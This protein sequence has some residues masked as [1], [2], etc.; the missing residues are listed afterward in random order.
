MLEQLPRPL[1]TI[2]SVDACADAFV[3]G[4]AGRRRHVDVP[5]WVG[6]LRWLK[7]L[8]HTAPVE[9]RATAHAA[10][11]IALMEREAGPAP[12]TRG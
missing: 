8:L 4:I 12:A 5:R 6:L 7:P 11:L 10:E 9:R 1:G 3:A 2:T